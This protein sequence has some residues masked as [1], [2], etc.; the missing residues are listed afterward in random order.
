MASNSEQLESVQFKRAAKESLE[1]LKPLWISLHN[2]HAEVAPQL[3]NTRTQEESWTIRRDEYINWFE[4]PSTFTIVAE[5]EKQLIGYAFIRI[6]EAKSATWNI[7]QQ[8]AEIETL[9]VLPEYR[10][11]GVGVG[12]LEHTFINLKEANILEVSLGVIA[13]NQTAID[14]YEKQGFTTT[15]HS[16]NKSL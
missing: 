7:T 3:G 5:L 6:R 14:F 12:L 8:I 16:M 10:G 1:F 11:F 2:H 15:L 9:S 13:S 4:N